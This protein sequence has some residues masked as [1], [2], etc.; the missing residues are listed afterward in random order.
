MN[1]L[2]GLLT[3]FFVAS[4]SQ[5][6]AQNKVYKI[7]DTT[8]TGGFIV[9]RTDKYYTE[10]SKEDLKLDV[11]DY[12]EKYTKEKDPAKYSQE[13][14]EDITEEGSNKYLSLIHI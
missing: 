6:F 2:I 13:H 8:P 7:G 9:S 14:A 4:T 5:V 1:K 3:V 11:K 10:A 12:V